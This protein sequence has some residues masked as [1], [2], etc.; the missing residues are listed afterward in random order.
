MEGFT[1]NDVVLIVS[2]IPPGATASKLH[3]GTGHRKD[4]PFISLRD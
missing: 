3:T 2:E 4:G 1:V